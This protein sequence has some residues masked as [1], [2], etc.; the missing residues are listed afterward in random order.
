MLFFDENEHEQPAGV[1]HA[2]RIVHRN[3]CV[4]LTILSADL[5]RLQAIYYI[6]T[7]I[8]RRVAFV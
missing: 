3:L 8:A 5:D 4:S 1:Q 2:T 7:N 6:E